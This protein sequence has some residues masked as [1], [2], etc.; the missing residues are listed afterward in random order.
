MT[1]NYFTSVRLLL[2]IETFEK[3][4]VSKANTIYKYFDYY[5]VCITNNHIKHK[6]MKIR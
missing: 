1:P 4:L 5:K 6:K 3:L 2:L